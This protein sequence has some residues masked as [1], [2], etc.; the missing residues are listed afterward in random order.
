M[1]ILGIDYGDNK[2]GIAMSDPFGWT[3]QGLETIKYKDI[4]LA[5]AKI[6]EIILKYDVDKIVV[7][8][9][10]NMNGSNGIRVEKTKVF[11]DR[12]KE[13]FNKDI[14]EWDERLSTV[15][16]ENILIA[17]DMRREKR[18]NVIDTVA[19][20]IILQGYLD[21]LSNSKKSE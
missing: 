7:G 10:K 16:A 2:I 1:R 19:A 21:F 8:M 6:K 9:P 12:L 17:G 18:K 11:I 4:K 5:I 14:V 3:A 15:A 13:F 20:S